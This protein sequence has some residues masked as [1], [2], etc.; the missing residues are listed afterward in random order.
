MRAETGENR[1]DAEDTE[2]AED[3]K[4]NELRNALFFL[5]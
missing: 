2:G 4:I 5:L 1:R 3:A